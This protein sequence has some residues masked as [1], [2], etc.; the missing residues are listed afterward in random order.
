MAQKTVREIRVLKIFIH[1]NGNLLKS[2]EKNLC[3]YIVVKSLK[4]LSVLTID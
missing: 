4:F 2:L 3:E 1:D